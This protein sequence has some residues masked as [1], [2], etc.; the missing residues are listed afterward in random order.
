M[1][2]LHMSAHLLLNNAENYELLVWNSDTPLQTLVQHEF[3]SSSS[4]VGYPAFVRQAA[5]VAKNL[6]WYEVEKMLPLLDNV[7]VYDNGCWNEMQHIG[8]A[9][10]AFPIKSFYIMSML[11]ELF[12]DEEMRAECST[13]PSLLF[14]KVRGLLQDVFDIEGA[15]DCAHVVEAFQWYSTQ[16]LDVLHQTRAFFEVD[17]VEFINWLRNTPEIDAA[18]IKNVLSEHVD[19]Q[20]V[21]STKNRKM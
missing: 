11:N 8:N 12:T 10:H 21:S 19:A 18:V 1:L 15:L 20:S 6:S 17:S 5:P 14:S 2:G 4:A 13:E 3:N 7:F 16:D 9:V